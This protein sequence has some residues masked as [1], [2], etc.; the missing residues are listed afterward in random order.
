MLLALE[1]GPL[2]LCFILLLIV[3]RCRMAIQLFCIYHV[4]RRTFATVVYALLRTLYK[5]HVHKNLIYILD[6]LLVRHSQINY[7]NY[8]EITKRIIY[9][10]D[11]G[12]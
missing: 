2:T 3:I 5:C 8:S 1:E 6:S 4:D 9:T 12:E 11:V 10:Y 7:T